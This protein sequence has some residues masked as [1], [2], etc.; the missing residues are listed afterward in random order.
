[1]GPKKRRWVLKLLQGIIGPT[2]LSLLS[3]HGVQPFV[4]RNCSQIISSIPKR[5]RKM[6]TNPHCTI[7]FF[8]I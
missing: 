3:L 2:G 7:F 4:H 8:G 6:I 1:M 5:E